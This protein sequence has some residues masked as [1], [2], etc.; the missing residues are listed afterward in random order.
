MKEVIYR[1]EPFAALALLLLCVSHAAN[2]QRMYKYRDVN[3]VWVYSDRQPGAGQAYQ[4]EVLQTTLDAP[5]VEVHQR[6]TAD[7]LSL[8]A[9]N[10]SFGPVEIAY[11]FA[12]MEN[13]APDTPAYGRMILPA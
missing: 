2:A 1:L 3:S 4:E 11:Q 6:Q 9:S 7:G 10:T 5:E 13:V 8:S 12:T